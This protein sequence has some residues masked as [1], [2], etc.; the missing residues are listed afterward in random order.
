MVAVTSTMQD[1]GTPAC[2]F[3]LPDTISG[4]KFNLRGNQNK[5]LLIMFICNHCPFVIHLIEPL[6]ALA[7]QAQRDGFFVAA[8]SSNDIEHYPQDAPER[9]T[10]FAKQYGFEFPYLYDQS[11]S[12]A[13]S[14]QAACTPDFF[15]YDEQ[16]KLKYRGQ[17][18][19]SRPNNQ[20]AVTGDDLSGAIN[21]VKQGTQVVQE[22]APSIGC[23]IKWKL[24]NE[25]EYFS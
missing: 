14:Y 13:K 19:S 18:D 1:L 23:N 3:C 5:P 10:E 24:G 16:H 6:V 8:I 12:V 21:A 11:Q 7:N 20:L 15:V 25:P 2:E 9:M 22:Q 17:M 4:E